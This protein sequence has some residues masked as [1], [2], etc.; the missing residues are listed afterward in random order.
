MRKLFIGMAALIASGA[1][2]WPEK[3]GIRF[4]RPALLRMDVSD[5]IT[6]TVPDTVAISTDFQISVLSFGG[7]CESK[8]P[9]GL[10]ILSNGTAELRPLDISEAT[11]GG[12]TQQLQTFTHTGTVRF[13]TGGAHAITVFGRDADSS[14]MSRVRSVFVK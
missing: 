8:G 4:S 3:Q 14:P 11:D 6:F 5:S 7:G 12:C 13:A 9:S 10:S 2:D 1:C